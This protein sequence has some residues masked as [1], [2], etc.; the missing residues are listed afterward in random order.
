MKTHPKSA[1][2]S[3]FSLVVTLSMMILLTAIAVGMLGLSSIA[4][5]SASSD[6]AKAIAQANA[7]MALLMALGEL[8]QE[9][10]PDTRVSATAALLDENP[11]TVEPDGVV[12]RNWLGV[13]ESWGGWLNAEAE[14]PVGTKISIQDTYNPGR[15]PMFRKWLVSSLGAGPLS[16]DA[17]KSELGD[18][19]IT[20][21]GD[22][23]VLDS[24]DQVSAAAID[25]SGNSSLSG[26]YAWWI[27]GQNQK[28]HLAANAPAESTVS[29]AVAEES[30]GNFGTRKISA[31]D[32][33]ESLSDDSASVQ[34]L[35][36]RQQIDLA[37]IS[38]EVRR[39]SFHDVTAVSD[40]VIADVRWGGLKK[41]L[42]L[43]FENSGSNELPSEFRRSSRSAPGPR[44]MSED[45][46]SQRPVM[47]FR[48]FTSYEMMH[49]YYRAYRS[50]ESPKPLKWERGAPATDEFAGTTNSGQVDAAGNPDEVGF[51][52]LPVFAK[53]YIIYS[54]R[55]QRTTQ[56]E[57][58]H[59]TDVPGRYQHDLS[60]TVAV[61][62]WNPYNVP[63]EIPSGSYEVYTLPY[64]ILPSQYRGYQN[65]AS[66]NAN[67]LDLSQTYS[68]YGYGGDYRSTI[69]SDDGS[70]I[71]FEPGQ[72]LVF[73]KRGASYLGENPGADTKLYPG[74]D[75][76]ADFSRRLR[77]Y[78]NKVD[79][80]TRWGIAIRLNPLW[81]RDGTAWWWGG[82]PGAFNFLDRNTGPT[83]MCY[84][85]TASDFDNALLAPTGG[86]ELVEFQPGITEPQP[87]AAV[88]VSLKTASLPDYTGLPALVGSDLPDYR[89]KNWIQ[90]LNSLPFLK[91]QVS[92]R[93][94]DLREQQ[95]LDSPYFLHFRKLSGAAEMAD[96]LSRDRT[97]R[98]SHLGSGT[99]GEKVYAVA[100][101]ELPSAPV[102][103]LAGF[104]GMPLR[105]G[106]YDIDS[107]LR[108]PSNTEAHAQS[109]MV[110]NISGYNAGVP[111]VGIGNSFASPMIPGDEVYAYHDVSKNWPRSAAPG[112][113]S[114]GN[115][116]RPTDALALSDYWDHAL[117]V[118]DG[119]WDSWFTSSIVS[120]ERPS[121]PSGSDHVSR[122]QDFFTN[123]EPLPSSNLVPY[124][125]GK[126]D[127]E[128]VAELK[129]ASSGYLKAAAYL[130]NR[131]SFNV[132]SASF[133]AWHALFAGLRDQSLSYRDSNGRL[134]Q[135]DPSGDTAPV[136][137]FITSIGAGEVDDPRDGVDNGFGPAWTGLRFLT[138][139]QLEKLAEEC[140]KQVKLRGP[141]LNLSDFV[142]RRLANDETGRSGALQS[143]IDYDD[144]N[145]D[146]KSINHRYKSAADMITSTPTPYPFDLAAT[147]S[148]FTGAPGYVIQSDLLRP[149]GNAIQVR[150]DTWVIRAY[151]D[152]RDASGKVIARAWCEAEVRRLPEYL[153]DNDAPETPLRVL[154]NSG[155]PS[156]GDLSVINQ[157]FGRKLEVISFRW[158]TQPE[159]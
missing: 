80:G 112:S 70:P 114:N 76:Y 19:S 45:L 75:P 150:D 125:S 121:N 97:N 30:S 26:R 122:M 86:S 153:D 57:R 47:R 62:L 143:A 53:Y 5:R 123:G 66:L 149:L 146:S 127:G 99:D 85:W 117:L 46:S 142:N 90:G 159:V 43:L 10:G 140:V 40:G 148:R 37:G 72:F 12:Q 44:P 79:D 51:R 35:V 132:N 31:L 94:A 52:R 152:A 138:N 118:N 14:T 68:I 56:N 83:G 55:T 136:S 131:S 124:P 23:S 120:T 77:I 144:S 126:T 32:G 157:K 96:L 9:M 22:G 109:R 133:K 27:G 2:Q 1:R 113:N 60:H 48:E 101:Q 105:P 24:A 111:G 65:G 145:P 15:A 107:A 158:L 63:L 16:M 54:L 41:D 81:N 69:V 93:D 25:V 71:R 7:R 135:I 106:W 147:G 49:E 82:N 155:S 38:K 87:F 119:L 108:P 18:E 134:R 78:S 130:I 116:R 102:I 73:S 92:Y 67:W 129:D 100:T 20:L 115:S 36:S 61:V 58:A 128:I 33:F 13:W 21:V 3:G 141:F 11:N 39:Q 88:G 84:D 4:L 139:Q 29:P 137:R 59:P 91:M 110:D 103:S 6:D 89:S 34:K 42:N 151:G 154:D 64:K 74:Y 17:A 8:Q 104:A 95:R 156:L 28:A 98:I 50:A